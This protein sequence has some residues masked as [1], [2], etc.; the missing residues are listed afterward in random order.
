MDFDL[1]YHDSYF[2]VRT[3]GDA[4][5]VTFEQFLDAML[6][7]TAWKPGTPSLHDH[8]RLNAAA[9]TVEDIRAIAQFCADRRHLLGFARFA[10]VVDRDLEFGLARMWGVF[11]E[12]RW[13]VQGGIFRQR[14][15]AMAW[16]L[17][18]VGKVQAATE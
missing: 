13:D 11:V 2:E 5:R 8:T 4:D 15:E 7:H 3:F 1:T 16:L 9:L 12:D 6:K 14:E 18:G 17:E 10:V